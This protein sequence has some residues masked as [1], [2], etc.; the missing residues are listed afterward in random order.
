MVKNFHHILRLDISIL[1][2]VTNIFA[3]IIMFRHA[4]A[5]ISNFS[6]YFLNCVFISIPFQLN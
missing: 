3:L 5:W 6:A 2:S 1:G 4:C